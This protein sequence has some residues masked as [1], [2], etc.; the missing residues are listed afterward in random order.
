[1][2]P[3]CMEL[4]LVYVLVAHVRLIDIGLI[5]RNHL[6]APLLWEKILDTVQSSSVK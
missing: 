5:P 2:P 6:V 4:N 3:S 1:M